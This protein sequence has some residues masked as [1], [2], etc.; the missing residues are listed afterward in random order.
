MLGDPILGDTIL[1]DT[2]LRDMMQH[3]AIVGR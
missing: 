2:T 1:G 3:V